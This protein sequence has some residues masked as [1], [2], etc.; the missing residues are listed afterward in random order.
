VRQVPAGGA[1][2]WTGRRENPGRFHRAGE[3]A[4]Y[5]ADG[6]DTAWAE[7]YR[8]L[9]E[10]ARA[11]LDVLPRDLYR[12]VVDLDSVL[13]LST[14][15]G[16][17]ANADATVEPT[18]ASIPG[19]RCGG[20]GR[21][22]TGGPVQLGGPRP[23]AVPVRVRSRPPRAERRGR[24]GSGDRSAPAAARP[25]HLIRAAPAGCGRGDGERVAGAP[26]GSGRIQAQRLTELVAFVEEMARNLR[27]ETLAGWWLDGNVDFLSGANRLDE[28][29]AGRYEQ[30]MQYALGASYGAFTY[31]PIEIGGVSE[32]RA[33]QR[34]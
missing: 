13:D 11:P 20:A 8:W 30:M 6:P 24:A 31:A 2:M 12:I 10:W 29:A 14:A 17:R 28:I 27:G 19:P 26:R 1:P 5:L 15:R 22:G 25:A 33:V 3:L 7:W 16:R 23:V 4:I 32:L 18:V 34:P 9:A 21:R